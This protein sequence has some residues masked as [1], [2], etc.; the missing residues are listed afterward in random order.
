MLPAKV[1]MVTCRITGAE[2]ERPRQRISGGAWSRSR[3]A[4]VVG[5][6]VGECFRLEFSP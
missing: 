2:P 1:A 5:E 4:A 6:G 3:S